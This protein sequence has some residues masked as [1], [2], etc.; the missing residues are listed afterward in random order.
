MADF[1]LATLVR[2]HAVLCLPQYT[3]TFR[4]DHHCMG[5]LIMSDTVSVATD[6]PLNIRHQP[7]AVGIWTSMP[8]PRFRIVIVNYS[9][10]PRDRAVIGYIIFS[11]VPGPIIVS[12]YGLSLRDG[13][14]PNI[15]REDT[16]YI[17]GIRFGGPEHV[18]R[19]NV[20]MMDGD[21]IEPFELATMNT[22]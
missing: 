10:L 14:F 5:T 16:V 22:R 2:R 7:Q 6:R 17:F 8:P 4:I 9:N 11:R 12:D 15:L 13:E 19:M 3:E 18:V 20:V 1:P 21:G